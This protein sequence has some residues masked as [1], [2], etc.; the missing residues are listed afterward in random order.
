MCCLT[1]YT[2]TY[3][4]LENVQ[5]MIK[6]FIISDYFGEILQSQTLRSTT[7]IISDW[8]RL[9]VEKTK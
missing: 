9:H 7:L 2:G 4:A 6:I 1:Q 5:M 3:R 8:K